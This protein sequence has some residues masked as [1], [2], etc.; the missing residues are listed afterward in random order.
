MFGTILVLSARLGRYKKL[1]PEACQPT[2]TVDML[3]VLPTIG[4]LTSMYALG[5]QA[6]EVPSAVQALMPPICGGS[7]TARRL[8]MELPA[9]LQPEVAHDSGAQSVPLLY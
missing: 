1:S 6:C 4:N 7:T 5:V 8:L 9:D 3:G 2:V